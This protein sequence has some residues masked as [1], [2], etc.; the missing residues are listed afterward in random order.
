MAL[1]HSCTPQRNTPCYINH[2]SH[3]VGTHLLPTLLWL[4]SPNSPKRERVLLGPFH[5][6]EV[7]APCSHVTRI[8]GIVNTE[9]ELEPRLLG[10]SSL[11]LNN[12]PTQ[13][14]DKRLLGVEQCP[15]IHTHSEPQNVTLFGSRS[16]VSRRGSWWQTSWVR[17]GTK[18]DDQ[19]LHRKRRGH[20][21]TGNR[22]TG[23][24]REAKD[25]TS[26]GQPASAG[27]PGCSR[28]ARKDFPLGLGG[29]RP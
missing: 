27:R 1:V 18:P 12:A 21:G 9:P 26:Q 10:V 7:E 8:I 28:G 13:Q 5:R 14:V 25:A 19:C 3:S 20:T 22:A 2:G 6:W 17:P 23:R 4:I 15:Q 29:S 11:A 16:F 24:G